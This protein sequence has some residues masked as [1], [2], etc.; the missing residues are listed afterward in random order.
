MNR[1]TAVVTGGTKGIGCQ[2][3]KDLL[4][5]N[6]YVFTN[7][8]HDTIAAEKAADEF[9]HISDAFKI[10]KA[11]QSDKEQFV[12]FLNIIKENGREVY[13]IVCNVGIT[14]RKST[15]EITDDEWEQV[16]RVNVA[17]HF[18]LIRDLYYNIKNNS[19]IVFIG[20]LLGIIPHSTS[21]V[22]GVSKAAIHA[23]AKNLIKEFEDTGTTVNII[24]PGFVETEWQ[25][26]KPL[27]IRENIYKKTAI[28]R[29]ANVKEISQAVMF[30]LDNP[31]INGSLIEVNGGYCFK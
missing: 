14:L 2:I 11:D 27:E 15:I 23:L 21:L 10:V 4:A 30:C 22:Y 5:R 31:Y 29:F 1:K 26:D 19:R 17:S 20:S 18:S 9:S 24:A 3:V 16:M 25:K 8:T 12:N 28:K 6:Y 7:Y 13:C